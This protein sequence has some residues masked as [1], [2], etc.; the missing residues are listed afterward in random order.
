MSQ[1]WSP[2]ASE[3]LSVGLKNWQYLRNLQ[4]GKRSSLNW[5]TI[6]T[7]LGSDWNV[8]KKGKIIDSDS[9]I[10]N[11]QHNKP[12]KY[13]QYVKY[14]RYKSGRP[15]FVNPTHLLILN[16]ANASKASNCEKFPWILLNTQQSTLLN[17]QHCSTVSTQHLTLFNTGSK[18]VLKGSGWVR[19]ISLSHLWER[20]VD[21]WKESFYCGDRT[22][23]HKAFLKRKCSKNIQPRIVNCTKM[24]SHNVGLT[25]NASHSFCLSTPAER[26][27]KRR[28]KINSNR[29]E[30]FW[31]KSYTNST[32]MV[33]SETLLG[34]YWIIY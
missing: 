25:Q 1:I 32:T 34:T 7:P 9:R 30:W 16:P 33:T 22:P 19:F 4:D 6:W 12:I 28:N 11:A 5:D 31:M 10:W 14:L 21:A 24:T 2:W 26:L 20:S 17:N 18:G 23:Q 29:R 8:S 13:I 3:I 15:N 27:K